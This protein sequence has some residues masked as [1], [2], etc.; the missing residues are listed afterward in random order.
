MAKFCRNCGSPL[1]DNALFCG[2]C[3]TRVDAV[4]KGPS[5]GGLS[6]IVLCQLGIVIASI[7]MVISIFLPI[8][9]TRNSGRVRSLTLFSERGLSWFAWG[10]IILGVAAILFAALRMWISSLVTNAL[11]LMLCLFL[12]V[13]GNLAKIGY[14]SSGSVSLQFGFYLM[15]ASTVAMLALS[16]AALIVKYSK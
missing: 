5:S 10:F 14:G 13:L 11:A 4:L 3:G 1:D 6:S 12:F 8:F 2:K 7:I 15:L 9:L 16:T